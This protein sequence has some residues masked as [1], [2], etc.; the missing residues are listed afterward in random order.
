MFRPGWRFLVAGLVTLTLF[1]IGGLGVYPSLLQRFRV[2]PNEL[3]AERPFIQH[4]IRLTRQAYG[5]DRVVEKEFSAADNLTAAAL[6]RNSLTIKNV[7]LWD[8]R[9]LLVTYGKLQEI[10]TYYKFLDVDVDRYTVNGEYRQVMLSARELSDRFLPSRGFINEHLT[11]THGSGLVASRSTG[12]APRGSR[13][14]S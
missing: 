8:N 7:R 6:E 3:V 12:S 9:P 13:S 11:Y 1:W 4:N 10:R 14:S 5:L 2:T